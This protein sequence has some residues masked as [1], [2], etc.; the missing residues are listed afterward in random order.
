MTAIC[1]LCGVA[2][3]G[4]YLAED[5]DSTIQRQWEYDSLAAHM[6]L[7]ITDYHPEQVEQGILCQRRAAKLYVINWART[8][9]ELEPVRQEWR[10]ALLVMMVTTARRNDQ[11]PAAGAPFTDL[12]AGGGVSS[13]TG[14]PTLEASKVKNES[15]K[16]SI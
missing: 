9:A 12:V 2:V 7:H 1:E 16:D 5:P 13:S 6:W 4:A 15:R 3:T 10:A 14:A 11:R 8:P